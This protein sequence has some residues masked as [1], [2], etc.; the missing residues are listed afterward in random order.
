[1]ILDQHGNPIDLSAI[2][3][4]QTEQGSNLARVGWMQR[5]F[6]NHPGRGL[7]PAKLN[8]IL[9]QAE[10]GDMLAGLDLADDMEERDGNIYAQLSTRKTAVV[11]LPLSVE[12]PENPSKDEEAL[13]AEVSEW[14]GD[15]D[16]LEEDIALELLDGI[17]KGFKPIEMWW[18]PNQGTLQPHFAPRPQRWLTMSEDRTR[19]NLR[20]NSAYGQPL[21]PYSWIVHQPKSRSGYVSR[22]GLYRVLALP[23]LYFNYS[24]RDLAEFLEIYGLPL[25]LGKYPSGASDAEK[26]KLLQ[27]VVQI[28]HNAA[29]IIPAGMSIDFAN[30]ASG[31]EKPFQAMMEAMTA[32]IAKVI[33]GQTLTSSEG[34]T[35]T[36]A[37]GTVHNEVRL[38]ILKSDAKRLSATLTQQLIAPMCLLNKPGVDPRRL[39][40][41]VIDVPEPEDLALYADALPKLAAAGMR[42]D[43]A[44]LHK[45]I[46]IP[47]ADEGAVILSGPPAAPA[48]GAPNAAPAAAPAGAPV[49]A[50]GPAPAPA[51]AGAPAPGKAALATQL[52]SAAGGDVLDDLVAE[53]TADW[54][55]VMEPMVAPLL[56]E[57]DKAVAAGESIEAF[58]A[59]LPELIEQMDSRPQ[60]ERMARAAFLA[61]LAGEA[62]L[63]PDEVA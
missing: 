2:R 25:R 49:P 63:D 20:D 55:P 8:A 7:T 38:D 57:L 53:A 9:N 59:R 3:E 6:E 31:T 43:V 24:N 15:I 16:N 61:R 14:V 56:A 39:P 28:G 37:L 41:L 44:D 10:R 62:D 33:L 30:A 60:A 50:P 1:M 22:H 40:R 48:P 13:A 29:G 21:N 54:R 47:E 18:E 11:N 45:R 36:Q 27:A 51:P 52:P 23:Y 26:R 32:I 58:R 4:P 42:F 12:P 17:L 46:R 34:N 35:G 19:L 5:E